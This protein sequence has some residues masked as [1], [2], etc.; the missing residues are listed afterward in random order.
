MGRST[1]V[2]IGG[3][4]E[5]AILA[6]YRDATR[7]GLA[8]IAPAAL[9]GLISI[10]TASGLIELFY[11]PERWRP[12]LGLNIAY[13]LS[14]LAH[15]LVVHRRP[16]WTV[17]STLVASW[18][19]YGAVISY[20][21]VT[22]GSAELCLL[23]LCALL[24]S[25][26][27][28]YPW[29]AAGQLNGSVVP[30]LGYAIALQAGLQ[31]TLPQV[32]P[33][34]ALLT[35]VMLSVLGAH[36]LDRHRFEAFRRA[37]L[38]ERAAESQR[39]ERALIEALLDVARAMNLAIGDPRRLVKELAEQTRRAVSVEWVLVHRW[40][41]EVGRY[42][43]V[44]AAGTPPGIA[45]EIEALTSSEGWSSRFVPM[46]RTVGA[47]EV[48]ASLSISEI[49]QRM[50]HRWNMGCARVQAAVRDERPVGVITC[51]RS[52]EHSSF[53]EP[54]RRMLEAIATQAAVA[55]E[56][57]GLVESARAADRL[58]SEFVATVSHELRTPLNVILGYVDLILDGT[59]GQRPAA[60]ADALQRV[61]HQ[62]LQLL[63]LIQSLLDINRL[64]ARGATLTLRR[65]EVGELIDGVRNGIPDSWTRPAVQLRWEPA[66]TP[67]T[68]RTDFAKLEIILRNLIHN[69]LKF[70]EQ[71]TVTLRVETRA[72]GGAV[73]FV[74]SD[75]GRGIAP[76]DLP[77]IFEM[78]GQGNDGPRAGGVGLGLYIVKRLTASL[79]GRI[80]V[81]SVPGKGSEFILSLPAD[82][83]SEAA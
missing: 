46:L 64:E 68:L 4:D 26:V 31:S 79:G 14:G 67:V 78:F 30:V 12:L 54:Q 39:E 8:A 74:V 28:I 43:L 38:L 22:H 72:G 65:F 36:R 32:Y 25:Q 66:S 69:A 19:V 11:F 24:T 73:R 50:F 2:E 56:N 1:D 58:K 60:E 10:G 17:A 76:A 18:I 34:F 5:A 9:I 52:A 55:L 63:E 41:G 80:E 59:F 77:V 48:G 47:V 13:G 20:F 6:E 45:D 61:R 40:V 53:T 3:D 71:G 21:T 16:R 27:I 70:T 83:M 62:S 81:S 49:P 51:V 33:L 82:T 42:V 75:T 15:L 29:N 35:M 23:I 7:Q 37:L 44:A 57:A